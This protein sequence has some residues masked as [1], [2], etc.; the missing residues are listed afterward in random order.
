MAWFKRK[1]APSIAPA[2]AVVK[3]KLSGETTQALMERFI[4]EMKQLLVDHDKECKARELKLKALSNL[5]NE[6]E[7]MGSAQ[8]TMPY[9]IGYR[10]ACSDM[11]RR[12][13]AM[14][15]L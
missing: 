4:K 1:S 13:Y 12:M 10:R 11:A 8:G 7:V 15:D 5:A 3:A 6:L 2:P 14:I 9:D